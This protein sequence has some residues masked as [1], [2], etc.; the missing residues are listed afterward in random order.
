MAGWD[1]S[2]LELRTNVAELLPS[3]DPA[4]EELQRTG[5]RASAARQV[6][7]IAVESPD[8]EANLRFAGA[9]DRAS[10]ASCRPT[11]IAMAAYDVR[12]ERAVLL[13]A[14]VAL[15]RRS[16]T[17]EAAARRAAR[18]RSTQAEEP[19]LRRPARRRRV[20]ATSIVEAPAQARRRA[21][22]TSPPATS[23]ATA[24]RAGLIVAIVSVRR[25][26]C[27]PSAPASSCATRRERLVAELR[28]PSRY[29]AADDRSAS[30]AT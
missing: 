22:T 25:A 8:R 2:H 9:L 10:C 11:L 18:R 1:A 13:G 17:L 7:Q 14:Q 12:D 19:A 3:K 4:V 26:A 16:T 29:H 5:R 15:R 30:P 23:R 24:A 6:L 20:A 21:S 28:I 27:S